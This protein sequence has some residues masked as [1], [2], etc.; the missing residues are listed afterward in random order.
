MTLGYYTGWRV[1]SEVLPLEWKQVDREAQTVRLEPG[2]TKNREARVLPYGMLPELVE[3]IETAWHEHQS[4]AQ[5]GVLSPYV[6][7]RDGQRIK[8][9]RRAWKSA[10]KRAG[11]PDK[12]VHDFRRTAVRNLTRAGVPDSVAMKITGHKT[13]SVF[14]RYN[15]TSEADLWDALGALAGQEKG[16]LESRGSRDSA[17]KSID[18]RLG[19]L[20]QLVELQ[21]FNLM[22]GGSIPS[23][24]TIASFHSAQEGCEGIW[25]V[26]MVAEAPIALVAIPASRRPVG[27]VHRARGAGL[28]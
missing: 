2:T 26:T 5:D 23:R 27:L 14:D 6:F 4:L 1:L 21:T 15:I 13:G 25:D 12:L 19:P 16:K 9:Y 7:H 18:T 28:D 20:A 22:V 3:V 8:D 24:P 11:L 17:K 10:C